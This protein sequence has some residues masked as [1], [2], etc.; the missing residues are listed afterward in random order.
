MTHQLDFK[1]AAEKRM[2]HAAMGLGF[3]GGVVSG[4]IFSIAAG[5]TALPTLGT[6]AAIG[7][8]GSQLGWVS[9]LPKRP[10]EKEIPLP[11][12]IIDRS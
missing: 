12:Q 10:E 7:F 2:K 1:K 9:A 3:V 5:L 11:F 8:L 4:A 6:L